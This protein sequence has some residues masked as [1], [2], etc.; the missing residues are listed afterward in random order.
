MYKRILTD[1]TLVRDLA[2]DLYLIQGRAYGTHYTNGLEISAGLMA[3]KATKV[4]NVTNV[5]NDPTRL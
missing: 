3:H 1:L 5:T 2:M 4:T